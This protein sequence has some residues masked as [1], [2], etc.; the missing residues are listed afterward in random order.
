MVFRFCN[1]YITSTQC[2][3]WK[4]EESVLI[5][6]FRLFICTAY[7]FLLHCITESK[8][9]IH[10]IKI[11]DFITPNQIKVQHILPKQPHVEGNKNSSLDMSLH[12]CLLMLSGKQRQLY[13]CDLEPWVCERHR[14]GSHGDSPHSWNVSCL[15]RHTLQEWENIN[16][17][18]AAPLNLPRT[19]STLAFIVVFSLPLNTVLKDKVCVFFNI[20][21]GSHGCLCASAQGV[22]FPEVIRVCRLYLSTE[23]FCGVLLYFA[24]L[25]PPQ[26]REHWSQFS[27]LTKT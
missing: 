6:G 9:P 3:E 5:T 21:S 26:S 10:L 13:W 23:K 18:F 1:R 17:R 14:F 25:K 16:S 11:S 2:K 19:G 7:V 24:T 22:I 12:G 27:K 15:F 4:R 8:T 20:C